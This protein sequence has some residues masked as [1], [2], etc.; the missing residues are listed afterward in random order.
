MKV[1]TIRQPWA[2]LIANGHKTCENRSWE[3]AHRGPLL[4]HASRNLDG[5]R[6]V[7]KI[8]KEGFD[9]TVDDG[10]GNKITL[11]PARVLKEQCGMI[12]AEVELLDCVPLG[13]ARRL[14]L[15]FAEGPLCFQ[16]RLVRRLARPVPATG[17]LGI[18]T[19]ADEAALA[20]VRSQLVDD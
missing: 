4:I 15:S 20:A 10:L 1:L 19:L 8:Q 5:Y 17:L 14:S 7:R 6:E 16:M 13:S 18:W 3:A 12:L 2:W 9:A 11:P